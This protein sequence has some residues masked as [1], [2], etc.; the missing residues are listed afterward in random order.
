M[1]SE[2]AESVDTAVDDKSGWAGASSPA[3]SFGRTF[4]S[5]A[6]RDFVYLWLGQITHAGALWMDMVART[7]PAVGFGM[8]AGVAADSFNRRAVLLTTKVVAFGLSA[9]FAVLV[10]SG[11][12]DLW[13]LYL[14][15]FLRGATMAFDQPAR[16]AMVPSIVPL[17]MV[18][19]AMALSSGSVQVMRILGAGGAGAII[20]LGGLE[21]VFVT[22]TAFYAAAVVLTWLLQVS[23]HK[24]EGYQ[25][26]KQV[27][28]DLVQ[29][30]QFAWNNVAVRGILMAS[31]GYSSPL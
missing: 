6:Y 22:I 20:A 12:I 2:A 7:V 3:F 23:D 16:R 4:A 17:Q 28:V 8:L 15:T 10:V 18:T 1:K 31:A 30:M 9:F 5:L 25:G 29:G 24:R 11:R 13:H 27:G 19:N 26:V 14:F 21:A